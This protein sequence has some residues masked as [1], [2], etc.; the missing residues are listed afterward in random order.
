MANLKQ[1]A[2]KNL[3]K[4]I[5]EKPLRV[6][7]ASNNGVDINEHFGHTE[8]F[9]VYDVLNDG[10][11]LVEI[12]ITEKFCTKES[13][14]GKNNGV[15][16]QFIKLLEDC[17]VLLCESIGYHVGETLRESGIDSYILEGDISSGLKAAQTGILDFISIS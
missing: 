8:K 5:A 12:R 3:S 6:A 14:H 4:E 9:Y 1:N 15:M 16:E 17:P 13:N 10:Y 11:D 7:V 2:V